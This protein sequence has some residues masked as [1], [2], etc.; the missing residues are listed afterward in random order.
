MNKYHESDIEDFYD[1]K[2]EF[3][4]KFWDDG[5][6]LHWAYWKDGDDDFATACL[7]WNELMLELSGITK[8][9]KVLDLGCGNGS[10]SIWLAEKAGCEVVGID[11]SKV[12]IDNAKEILQK[13]PLELRVSFQKAS[14]TDLPFEPDTFTHVWSQAVLYNVPKLKDGLKEVF[15]VLKDMGTFIFDDL[16]QPKKDIST[17]GRTFVYDRLL[18]DGNPSH[19]EYMEDLKDIGFMLRKDID[20]SQHLRRSYEVLSRKVEPICKDTSFAYGKM[21]E[22]MDRNELGWSFFKCQKVQDR[23]QWVY[24]SDNVLELE[25][26]Y[27]MWADSYEADL[28]GEYGAPQVSARY[29]AR[30]LRDKDSSILD[31]GCGTGLVGK[32]LNELGYKSVH[33]IDI[34]QKMIQKAKEKDVYQELFRG[35]IHDGLDQ[36]NE[37]ENI[38]DAMIAVGVFTI[39]HAV[40]DE[41]LVKLL[42]LL[43][44]G[45]LFAL[46]VRVDFHKTN[47]VILQRFI[48]QFKLKCLGVKKYEIFKD[49]L[50]FTIVYKKGVDNR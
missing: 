42:P 21:C 29:L 45:G 17:D 4:R 7:R 41:G 5:G 32:A 2:D 27:D 28:E 16:V 38:Y 36:K 33:G 35:N 12:R 39:N 50:M 47:E 44:E 46:T 30:F 10:N 40:I 22:A 15:R 18:F 37:P 31:I 9:S 20:I 3:Y 19:E 6:M 13:H 43:R 34:S 24:E 23:V 26:R 8:E 11:I 48:D 25:E 49:E 1:T 14:I